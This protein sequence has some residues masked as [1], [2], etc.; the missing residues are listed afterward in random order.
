MT[1]FY[2]FSCFKST[3]E[4]PNIEYFYGPCG[5]IFCSSCVPE[6]CSVCGRLFDKMNIDE[7]MTGIFGLYFEKVSHFPDIIR[8]ATIFQSKKMDERIEH[9]A[10][11]VLPKLKIL[12]KKRKSIQNQ[13]KTVRDAINA[14][15]YRYIKLKRE[16]LKY[17]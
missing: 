5:H 14:S 17:N 7:N 12:E 3:L 13:T 10:K 11:D 2:C 9:L 1:V 4:Y 8:E 6:T 16:I 15:N